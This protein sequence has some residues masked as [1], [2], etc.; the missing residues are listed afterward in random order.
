MQTANPISQ[1]GN[2]EFSHWLMEIAQLWIPLPNYIGV[3]HVHAF[4]LCVTLIYY[5]RPEQNVQFDHFWTPKRTFLPEHP[6]SS[7]LS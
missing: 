2:Y 6:S 7:E 4:E 1:Y 3:G 5:F